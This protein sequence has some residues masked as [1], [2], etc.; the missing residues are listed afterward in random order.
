VVVVRLQLRELTTGMPDVAGVVLPVLGLTL[1]AVAGFA[2][3]FS[4]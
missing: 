4:P 3:L 1:A 2:Q